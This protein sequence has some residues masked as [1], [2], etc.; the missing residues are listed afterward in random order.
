MWFTLASDKKNS[1]HNSC[2]FVFNN[3]NVHNMIKKKEES[4]A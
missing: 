3:D 1:N 2:T 4:P